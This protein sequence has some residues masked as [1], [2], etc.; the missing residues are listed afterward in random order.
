MLGESNSG[1]TSIVERLVYNRFN[2]F[3]TPTI[4]S[5]FATW[6]ENRH[7][8]R[9]CIWDTA[10]SERYRSLLPLYY[11]DA[12][13]AMVV[14]DVNVESSFEIAKT[15]IERSLTLN[16]KIFILLVGNK[17]DMLPQDLKVS[18]WQTFYQNE[19]DKFLSQN[20]DIKYKTVSAKT[21]LGVSDSFKCIATELSIRKPS[22]NDTTITN[23]T[24]P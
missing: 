6:C 15:Y 3:T 1:K 11:R 5:S 23:I 18:M 14:F 20:R 16:P 22:L 24:E 12:A 4:G 7:D 9:L 10:G 2:P 19:I 21:G 13:A 8:I 17:I